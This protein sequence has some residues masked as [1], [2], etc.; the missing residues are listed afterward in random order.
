MGGVVGG[1]RRER[2]VLG[3]CGG[4]QRGAL[5]D[6]A[7]GRCRGVEAVVVSKTRAPDDVC[8]GWQ[9]RARLV[10]PSHGGIGAAGESRVQ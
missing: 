10:A 9:A 1:L 8:C 4:A 6:A 5:R 2:P 3:G 7:D